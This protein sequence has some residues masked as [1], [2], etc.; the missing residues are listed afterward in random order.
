[1]NKVEKGNAYKLV[2]HACTH[3]NVTC[4][5]ASHS[6]TQLVPRLRRSSLRYH[7]CLATDD[8]WL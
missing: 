8:R 1:M 3:H 7:V 4:W 6:L 2:Q 5:L